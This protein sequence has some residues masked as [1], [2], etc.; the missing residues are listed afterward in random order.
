MTQLPARVDAL[1]WLE[2][3]DEASVEVVLD[4]SRVT[5][6]RAGADIELSDGSVSRL[7]AVFERLSAAWV[8]HDLGSTNGTTVNGV[9]TVGGRVIRDGDVICFGSTT[10]T[11]RSAELPDTSLTAPPPVM[12]LVTRRERDVLVALCRPVLRGDILAPPAGL[13][14]IA[15]ELVIS[16]SAVKKLLTRAYDRFGLTD[17][18]R[19][20]NYLAAEALRR[21]VVTLRDM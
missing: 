3:A 6:G 11:F 9:R 4:G 10:I 20:R 5:V 18:R 15:D 12:P 21:G 2:F 7:H 16:E 1:V 13:K 19:R 8:V 17:D 14:E